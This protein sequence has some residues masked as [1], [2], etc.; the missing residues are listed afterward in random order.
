MTSSF[1]TSKGIGKDT[2]SRD[3]PVDGG[4]GLCA[5]FS[6]AHLPLGEIAALNR[7]P[8]SKLGCRVFEPDEFDEHRFRHPNIGCPILSLDLFGKRGEP[9]H[10]AHR[11]LP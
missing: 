9:Q 4:G 10:L 1:N 3:Q 6:P 11:A 8:H 2:A 7:F 5:C